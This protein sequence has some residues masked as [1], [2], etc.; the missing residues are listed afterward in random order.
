[1][2]SVKLKDIAR[3]AHVTISTASAALNGAPGVG[4]EKRKLIIATAKELGY[5]PNLAA[6][7]LKSHDSKVLGLTICDRIETFSGH[8]V[9]SDLIAEMLAECQSESWRPSISL[10]NPS[11]EGDGIPP[12]LQEGLI[13]G[14]VFCGY[15]TD[16]IKAWLRARPEFPF[17]AFNEPWDYCVRSDSSKG[18]FNAV[19]YLVATGHKRIFL[20]C[21]PEKYDIHKQTADGYVRAAKEF[22][23]DERNVHCQLPEGS[24]DDNLP[25]LDKLFSG[26]KAPDALI[27]SGRK[28]TATAL[29]HLARK[30][31]FVPDGVSVISVC[32]G[33]EA[34]SI[35]PE[36]STIQF[37]IRMMASMAL[38][39]LSQRINGSAPERREVWVEPK[40]EMRRTVL[41]RARKAQQGGKA[42]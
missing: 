1:M 3:K 13:S 29:Y 40:L 14:C 15:L 21:G 26:S 9:Y 25:L 32:S 16:K 22:G 10:H 36:V 5:Y 34:N 18:V 8:G 31:V 4:D 28:L 27:L 37:D 11:L 7:L 39:L 38:K 35:Y 23:L 30:G 17:V 33:W 2:G 19:Q 6:K 42:I 41:S 20:I 24:N 12:S